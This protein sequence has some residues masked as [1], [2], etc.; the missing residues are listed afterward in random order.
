M[1]RKLRIS[2]NRRDALLALYVNGKNRSEMAA[3]VGI[4]VAIVREVIKDENFLA[5]AATI[6]N[7]RLRRLRDQIESLGE[8]AVVVH[9]IALAGTA[10]AQPATAIQLAAAQS[11]LDRIGLP[12]VQVAKTD[13]RG[14]VAPGGTATSQF[15]D[16]T[17]EELAF[18]IAHGKWPHGTPQ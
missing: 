10:A 5:E 17:N 11:I 2:P 1:K 13:G 4:S 9:G 6:R 8:P 15:A 14:A 7:D 3:E 18:Y 12:R 16:R